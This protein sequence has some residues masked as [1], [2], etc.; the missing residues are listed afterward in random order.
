MI[1]S[2]VFETSE[3]HSNGGSKFNDT[4]DSDGEISILRV[5]EANNVI[6]KLMQAIPEVI[7]HHPLVYIRNSVRTKRWQRQMQKK[8][9][10][11]NAYTNLDNIDLDSDSE[12]IKDGFE[13]ETAEGHSIICFKKLG[14]TIK[15]LENE[16]KRNKHKASII[17]AEAA[18]KGV[19]HAHCIRSWAINYIKNSAFPILRQAK[20]V[21]EEILPSLCFDP[22]PTICV[23]TAYKWLKTF[24]FEY[25][26]VRK[27]IYIDSHERADM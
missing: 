11:V 26:E 24:S 17:V 16:I 15:R 21:N 10:T 25:S 2:E 13:V 3:N 23:R 4:E 19:Y 6:T 14:D 8:A 9:A 7:T 18:V 1:I 22:S 12:I 27:G 20:H 5:E